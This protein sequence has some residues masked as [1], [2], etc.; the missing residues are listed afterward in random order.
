ML[1]AR[2]EAHQAQAEA[3]YLNGNPDAAI[4]QLQIAARL[5]R[6]NFYLQS[7]I[8]ARIGA[9]REEMALYRGSK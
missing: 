7:S 8:E 4:E 9:I 6:D 2:V 1:G 5:V 3:Q